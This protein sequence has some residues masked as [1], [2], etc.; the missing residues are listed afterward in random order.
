MPFSSQ[1][2]HFLPWASTP[3]LSY[4]EYSSSHAP[5]ELT[6]SV[7]S[8]PWQPVGLS[9]AEAV[10]VHL[11]ERCLAHG[12]CSILEVITI[13]K[14]GYFI[15]RIHFSIWGDEK[16][17]LNCSSTKLL[18]NPNPSFVT[19]SSNIYWGPKAMVERWNIW[20]L[21]VL[22]CCSRNKAQSSYFINFLEDSKHIQK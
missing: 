17:T 11:P 3:L 1:L 8:P 4:L 14:L 19:S 2:S 16:N 15:K 5:L 9:R 21:K 13:T 20:V 6:V 18:R 22:C 12:R 7:A 10:C